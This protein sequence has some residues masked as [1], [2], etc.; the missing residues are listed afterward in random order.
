[1]NYKQTSKWATFKT[2]INKNYKV[3]DIILR[4]T[5]IKNLD[6]RPTYIVDSYRIQHLVSQLTIIGIV[7]IVKPGKYK[8]ICKIPDDMNATNLINL[9]SDIRQYT[10][11]RWFIPIEERIN[12]GRFK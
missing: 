8:L 2:H 5:L 1:M 11:K 9:V 7:E 3:G 6:K 12:N 4:Q 10:W